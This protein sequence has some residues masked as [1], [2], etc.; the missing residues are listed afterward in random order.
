MTDDLILAPR[1]ENG[2]TQDAPRGV[3]SR[4]PS[5]PAQGVRSDSASIDGDLSIARLSDGPPTDRPRGARENRPRP[6]PDEHEAPQ[7]LLRPSPVEVGQVYRRV[8]FLCRDGTRMRLG[9]DS[10]YEQRICIVQVPEGRK[11]TYRYVKVDPPRGGNGRRDRQSHPIAL[12][13]LARNYALETDLASPDTYGRESRQKA[14]RHERTCDR[15]QAAIDGP[16]RG[17]RGSS[18]RGSSRPDRCG[19][20]V[21]RR[22]RRHGATHVPQ[23]SPAGSLGA[24]GMKLTD[25]M[26]HAAAEAL[27]DHPDHLRWLSYADDE[28]TRLRDL[29]GLSTPTGYAQGKPNYPAPELHRCAL[30]G[31]TCAYGPCPPAHCQRRVGAT[32]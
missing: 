2:R 17:T 13:G 21:A 31:A 29:C 10:Q 11:R 4:H 5:P 9:P 26:L 19:E 25:P 22:E 7:A 28:M 30:D 23:L 1:G 3:P 20:E 12:Q 32:G 6:A 24:G 14:R 18:G 8:P 16:T 27:R 15:R